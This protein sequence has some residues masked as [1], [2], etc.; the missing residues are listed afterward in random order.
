MGDFKNALD[1]VN[2]PEL[3]QADNDYAVGRL[4]QAVAESRRYRDNTLIFVIEDDAQDGPDHV[5]AHRSTAYIVGPYV[6]QGAV[7][8]GYY[9]TVNLL[10]TIEDVLGMD[11]L[12]IF[13]ANARP[14]TEVFD[15]TQVDWSFTATPSMLLA[16]TQLPIPGLPKPGAD[17]PQPVHPAAYWAEMTQGMDFSSEDKVD[18]AG[19]NRIVWR[20]LMGTPYPEERSGADLRDGRAR[21]PATAPKQR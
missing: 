17:T 5:D 7:V 10:R 16:N 13:D 20:G 9:T 18:A 3:Q 15:L 14:M 21:L 1:G 12:S 4:I 6:K 19:F 8:S 2:T 11:H